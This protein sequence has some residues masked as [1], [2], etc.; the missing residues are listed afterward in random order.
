MGY[1]T[2]VKVSTLAVGN[3]IRS[4]RRHAKIMKVYKV[5]PAVYARNIKKDEK[6]KLKREGD[7]IV[8]DN[9]EEIVIKVDGV[10]DASGTP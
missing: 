1:G 6:G 5:D 3:Y 9:L 2:L 4:P 7:T 8:L 10:T